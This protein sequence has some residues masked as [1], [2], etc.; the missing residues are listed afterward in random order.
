MDPLHQVTQSLQSHDQVKMNWL[1]AR[2]CFVKVLNDFPQFEEYLHPDA[3]IVHSSHFE[4]AIVKVM[5]GDSSLLEAAEISAI[6]IFKNKLKTQSSN[7]CYI[8]DE[9]DE[10]Y[11]DLSWIPCTSNAC[12][13]LFSR[14]GL[15]FDI[16]SPKNVTS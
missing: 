10:P 11:M 4:K 15:V 2:K 3:N 9:I 6:K 14:C 8:E 7:K 12:E 5:K 13:R 1:T 16:L